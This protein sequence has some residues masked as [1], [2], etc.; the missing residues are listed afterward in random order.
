MEDITH[1]DRNIRPQG[2]AEGGHAKREHNQRRHGLLL[3]DE[4]NAQLQAGEHRLFRCL[5][6]EAV[7]DEKQSDD[8]S[9]EGSG[10]Q[11]ET[12]GLTDTR[13]CLPGKCR[14]N[15]YGHVE[16]N[17]IQRD[18]VRHVFPVD[19]SGNQG[20]VRGP[21][22]RLRQAGDERETQNMPDVDGAG[23]N[24]NRQQPRTCEL[25]GL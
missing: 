5:R 7:G 4:L 19:Q 17:R 24:Q 1:K 18:G 20:L 11:P 6:H 14:S 13:Q 22:E 8:R 12:P 16:L 10:I 15:G 2:H 21:S 23:G 25:H 3:A 9:D